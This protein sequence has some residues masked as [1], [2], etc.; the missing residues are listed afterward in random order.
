MSEINN[1][2]DVSLASD[3]KTAIIGNDLAIPRPVGP[4]IGKPMFSEQY[5]KKLSAGRN[6]VPA[7]PLLLFL[8]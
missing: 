5:E 2:S 8:M 6:K 3:S 7:L 4:G 1:G